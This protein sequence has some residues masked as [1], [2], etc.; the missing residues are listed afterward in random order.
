LTLKFLTTITSRILL[1]SL[2]TFVL[3]A[4]SEPNLSPDGSLLS[5]VNVNGTIYNVKFSDGIVG[6]AWTAE[7]V[8]SPGWSEFAYHL[9]RAVASTLNSLTPIPAPYS[10]SGCI[11]ARVCN[12]WLPDKY[13]DRSNGGSFTDSGILSRLLLNGPDQEIKWQAGGNTSSFDGTSTTSGSDPRYASQIQYTLMTF[14]PAS[15]PPS[16]PPSE[17]ARTF[18]VSLE[19]PVDGEIHGGIGNLRGWAI[20]DDGIDRI[21]IFVDGQYMFDAPYGGWR[22]DVESLYPS[23]LNSVN[24]GFSLAFGYSNLEIGTHT[25][26]ARAYTT[27]G[28]I[29]E[30]SSS[31]NVIS[32]HKKFIRSADTVSVSNSKLSSAGDEILIDNVEVDGAKYSLKLKWRTAEQGFEIIDIQ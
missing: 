2:C 5:G 10:I 18:E 17:P 9:K 30:S 4:Y 3:S 8:T 27:Q 21:E 22:T 16:A 7:Q 11:D 1:F 6:E 31:F 32:F 25:I 24:S 15:A 29:R 26:T 23:V 13:L 28:E 19:E 12:L 14:Y 20:A